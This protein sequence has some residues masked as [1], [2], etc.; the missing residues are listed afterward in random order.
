MATL[1][2]SINL[3]D[4]TTDS[5]PPK[6]KTIEEQLKDS[7]A[8]LSYARQY[9]TGLEN[10]IGDFIPGWDK[11]NDEDLPAAVQAFQ[12]KYRKIEEK[13][14]ANHRRVG[15]LEEALTSRQANW[16]REKRAATNK[17]AESITA[18]S[19]KAVKDFK[20]AE[21]D[22][23][24]AH[25]SISEQV[26]ELRKSKEAA[27]EQTKSLFKRIEYLRTLLETNNIEYEGDL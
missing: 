27:K 5:P 15:E 14:A 6:P 12:A 1:E 22:W 23:R 21:S 9:I 20:A 19:A 8:A 26:T 25:T 11:I 24:K 18:A 13:S 7:T 2:P 16:D 10:V 3:G 4:E 17:H